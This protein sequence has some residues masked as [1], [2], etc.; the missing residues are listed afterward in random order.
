MGQH[1]SMQVI[2]VLDSVLSGS[3]TTPGGLCCCRQEARCLRN[4]LVCRLL[5]SMC[6]SS[7][8]APSWLMIMI[9]ATPESRAL[10]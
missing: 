10:D 2:P 6:G 9:K 4:C 1:T 3:I 5:C 8:D 7:A